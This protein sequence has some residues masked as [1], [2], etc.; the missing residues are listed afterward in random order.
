[1]Q[2]LAG[3]TGHTGGRVWEAPSQRQEPGALRSIGADTT[4]IGESQGVF[5]EGHGHFPADEVGE[6][7]SKQREWNVQR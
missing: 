6:G 1:M 2:S 5:T 3:E 4:L 7:H